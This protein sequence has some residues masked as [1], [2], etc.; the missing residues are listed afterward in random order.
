MKILRGIALFLL[1]SAALALPVCAQEAD[2]TGADF[3]AEGFS[4]PG[5][6]W[7]GRRDSWSSAPDGGRVTV[8]RSDGVAG[9][10]IEFDRLPQPWTLNGD[11]PCG[12]EGTSTS[13][14]TCPPC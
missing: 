3:S 2:C 10:Y 8:S 1:L 9:L 14:W 11:I 4:N 6:L 12:E 13:T 7:D 5:R